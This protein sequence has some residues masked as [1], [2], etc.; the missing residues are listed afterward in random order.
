M[1]I[2]NILL[3]LHISAGFAALV[4]GLIPMLGKK[5]GRTH[6]QTGLGYVIAMTLVFITAVWISLLKQNSFL[7]SIGV[8][9]YYLTFTGF[10]AIRRK[11]SRSLIDLLAASLAGLVTMS[12]A[13]TGAY[14]IWGQGSGQ[15]WVLLIFGSLGGLFA[16]R[17]LAKEIQRSV[18]L[19][20]TQRIRHHII[21]MGGSYIA[22]FSAFAVTNFEFLPPLVNWLL[23]TAVGSILIANATRSW[24]KRM[25]RG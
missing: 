25:Q 22:T 18:P 8:F 7:L 24:Q 17:D 2:F 14:L 21:R 1:T 4:L 10:R 11:G 9:S 5:G 3:G 20:S 6:R 23:P 16:L 19:D 13:G 12:M 15:G